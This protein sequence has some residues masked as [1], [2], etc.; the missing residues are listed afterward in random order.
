MGSMKKER[1]KIVNKEELEFMI[2]EYVCKDQSIMQ[3]LGKHDK[4]QT[5]KCQ[6]GPEMPPMLISVECD[7]SSGLGRQKVTVKVDDKKIFPPNA[8][9]EQLT[10]P[11]IK[12][13][14]FRAQ[15]RGIGEQGMFEARLPNSSVDW[16]YPCT[17]QK[18][19][20]DGTFKAILQNFP[21]GYGDLTDEPVEALTYE[22]I[23]EKYTMQPIK[24]P[25]ST[26]VLT[27]PNDNPMFPVLCVN[28]RD[29]V[30]HAFA[31][32]TPNPKSGQPKLTAVFK[33]DKEHKNVTCDYGR[34]YLAEMQRPKPRWVKDIE[35]TKTKKAWTFSLGPGITHTVEV[36]KKYP[37][38][39][40]IVT[41]YV[42]GTPLMECRGEDIDCE[43]DSFR[44]SFR[45][46][47][48]RVFIFEVHE[49]DANG[50]PTSKVGQVKD[51]KPYAIDCQ[52][53]LV[54]DVGSKLGATFHIGMTE[55]R[56]FDPKLD[57][58]AMKRDG[59]LNMTCDNFFR[60]L[61]IKVPHKVSR[62]ARTGLAGW[63]DFYD[64]EGIKG[65]LKS[66]G[67]FETCMLPRV[68]N[69][70]DDDSGYAADNRRGQ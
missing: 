70:P 6:F 50:N 49:T 45:F 32:A 46:V 60:T 55:F 18:Q 66:C 53:Q 54:Q 52:I 1:T 64:A 26:L 28:G 58:E 7:Q 47:G 30:T 5:W 10:Q 27:V 61:G 31:R 68:D 8:S 19:N 29:F 36:E 42:D 41:I 13:W 34:M 25:R 3:A 12:E 62:T 65:V 69:N 59:P 37:K 43:K 16:W 17:L 35:N 24:M 9:K 23:R 21:N 63:Y 20:E 44:A 56:D 15:A 11:F 2:T 22:N 40:D 33:V 57:M 39:G 48:E 14:P 4:V 38:F 67:L 51:R